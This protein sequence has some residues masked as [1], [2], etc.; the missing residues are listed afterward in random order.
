MK[1]FLVTLK[2][3]I[4]VPVEIKASSKKEVTNKIAKEYLD[5]LPEN[6]VEDGA[7]FLVNFDMKEM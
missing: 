6:I 7:F 2:Y 5:T 3:E 1:K 4:N